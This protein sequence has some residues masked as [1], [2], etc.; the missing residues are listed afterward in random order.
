M[1][2]KNIFCCLSSLFFAFIFLFFPYFA[3]A[4]TTIITN[5]PSAIADDSFTITAS[6]S[7]ATTGTNYLKIDLFE[8][9]TTNYFGETFNGTDWYGGSTFS[10][11]LSISVQN[12]ATWSGTLQGRIGGPS[13]SQYDGTGTYKM[14]LRR[15]TGGGGYTASEANNSAV[16]ISIILPTQTPIP[17]L[18]PAPTSIPTS[19]PTL[20]PTK[21]P[22]LSPSNTTIPKPSVSLPPASQTQAQEVLGENIQN[23]SDIPNKETKIAGSKADNLFAK[24]MMVIGLIL[25]TCGILVF[26]IYKI[27]QS[28]DS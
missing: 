17:T 1:F 11:Y 21:T 22:T 25:F 5:F 4:V 7:G 13:S 26:R 2:V 16:T 14:R 18:T 10:Q 24:S 15:Y 19:T 12:S 6:I 9:Q 28:N 27:K 8:D 20:I 23:S 3:F